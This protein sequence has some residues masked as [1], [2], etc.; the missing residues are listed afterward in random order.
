MKAIEIIK[1]NKQIND[2]KDILFNLDAIIEIIKEDVLLISRIERKYFADFDFTFSESAKILKTQLKKTHLRAIKNFL[3][4]QDIEICMKFLISRI[5]NIMI[6]IT[7]N[8]KYKLFCSPQIVK[9]NDDIKLY[10]DFENDIEILDLYKFDRETIKTG[11]KDVY[12]NTIG[13]INFDLQDFQEL[14][15][16]FGFTLFDILD[17][18]PNLVPQM[19][20]ESSNNSCY[21]LVLV[22]DKDIAK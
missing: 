1:L 2:S 5:L 4:E 20:L 22:F 6:N 13:D 8:K 15:Q 10:S 7:I 18:N 11:L 3:L 21:Q 9:F 19:S 16:E 14:A 17:Y 12:E